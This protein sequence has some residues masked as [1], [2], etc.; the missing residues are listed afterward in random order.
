MFDSP[1][2]WLIVGGLVLGA[3]FGAAA[4]QQRMCLVAAVS[5]ASLMRDYRYLLGFA[6]AAIVAISGTQLLEI[7]DMVAVQQASYRDARLDWLGVILGGLVFG[8]GATYAGGDAARVV[9]LAGQGNKAGWIA[10]FFFAVFASVAQFGLLEKTRVYL[11]LNTSLNLTGGDAG[12]AALTSLPKWLM[13]VIVDAILLG[14]IVRKF[15]QHADLKIMI[16]GIL[17]GLTVIG[18][19]YTTGVLSQD[20][21][22]PIKPSAMTV[23]GP[24]SRIGNM[25]VS[26]DYPALSFSIAFVI[27]LIG[28]AF[29]LSLISGQFKFSPVKGSVSHVAVGGALMGIGGTFAYGCNVGQGFSGLSTLSL[30]SLLAVIAML[31]GIHLGTRMMEKHT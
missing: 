11:M 26:G 29:L 12:L 5:N 2:T 22:E 24:M 20:E 7:S 3:V 28:V 30:E 8:I 9:I 15:K 14:F 27:G 17:L 23:S 6:L 13:L 31:V 21:F 18:A 19:W 10:V 16:A 1:K 25:V 4:R